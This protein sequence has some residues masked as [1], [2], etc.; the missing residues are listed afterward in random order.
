MDPAMFVRS[1]TRR[2]CLSRRASAAAPTRPHGMHDSWATIG[3]KLGEWV[4]LTTSLETVGGERIECRQGCRP[5]LGAAALSR[6][7]GVPPACTA[8]GRVRRSTETDAPR[9]IL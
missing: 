8:S 3:R 6:A 9:K 1:P 2:A 5:D 4:R 7:V